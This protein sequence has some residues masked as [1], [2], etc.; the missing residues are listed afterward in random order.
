[1]SS[2]GSTA[3][4]AVN[5]RALRIWA[6]GSRENLLQLRQHVPRGV[7]LLSVGD[8]ADQEGAGEPRIAR[9]PQALPPHVLPRIVVTPRAAEGRGSRVERVFH[10]V[11][12]DVPL[13]VVLICEVRQQCLGTRH[14]Y[15]R[16]RADDGG[17]A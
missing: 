14:G 8:D 12:A 7:E 11:V 4:S 17:I 6:G 15:L 10:C 1:M 16:L 3:P 2:A 5:D 9:L 13:P